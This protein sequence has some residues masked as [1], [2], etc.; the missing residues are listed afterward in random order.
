LYRI[1]KGT[2]VYGLCAIPEVREENKY[3]IFRPM[4]E[5]T[6][7]ETQKYCKEN[8]LTPSIDKSNFDNKYARNHLRLNI[9]PKLKEMN[10]N[11][12]D[13]IENLSQIAKDYEK[14][15][16]SL[17]PSTI[18]AKT[19][20]DFEPETQ[21]TIVHK[22][23]IQNK[24]DYNYKKIEEITEFINENISKPCGNTISLTTE[25]WFFVSKE[26]IEIINNIKAP[27]TD[28]IIKLKLNKDN[29]FVS[30]NKILRITE[31]Q[32]EI[33]AKFPKETDFEAFV[34]LP[35]NLSPLELRTRQEGDIIQPFGLDGTMKLKK[36][37]INKAI[38]EYKRDEILLL[39]HKKEVLWAIGVGI[40][41]KLRAN[42]KPTHIIELR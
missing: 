30:L 33:P 10:P 19:F 9:I 39:T 34:N 42:K 37:F 12:D 8:H 27:K 17:L 3:K 38:P 36:F 35:E 40:S 31:F 26:K 21:K 32:G 1:I 5:I 41:E 13:A 25:K 7:E 20:S 28:E 11:F 2:G 6:R 15:L 4:L 29:Y 16:S 24:I 22:F 23:L 14:I 18:E